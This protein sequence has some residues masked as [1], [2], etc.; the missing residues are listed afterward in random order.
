MRSEK[1]YDDLFEKEVNTVIEIHLNVE[2]LIF[3]TMAGS[4]LT[5]EIVEALESESNI[6]D[7]DNVEF[8]DWGD[9]HLYTI[10]FKV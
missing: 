10:P 3:V 2:G 8:E 1:E 7:L 4:D 9:E 5:K 6:F